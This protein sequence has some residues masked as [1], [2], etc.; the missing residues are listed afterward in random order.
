MFGMIE[1]G[2][3]IDLTGQ[4]D[5]MYYIR[6]QNDRTFSNTRAVLLFSQD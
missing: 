2:S 4:Q 1:N 5:G 3:E 6:V